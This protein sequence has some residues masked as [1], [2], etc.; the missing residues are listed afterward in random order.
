MP[1]PPTAASASDGHDGE[2][3]TQQ[4]D[5]ALGGTQELGQASHG[6]GGANGGGGGDPHG[7]PA[8]VAAPWAYT[9]SIPGHE[10]HV[11]CLA[12]HPTHDELAASGGKDSAVLLWDVGGTAKAL[13]SL[14]PHDPLDITFGRAASE[15]CLFVAADAKTYA[16]GQQGNGQLSMWDLEAGK[17]VYALPQPRGHVSCLHCAHHGQTFLVGAA[18]GTVRLMSSLDGNE[19][20][21]FK[22]GMSDVNLVSLLRRDICASVG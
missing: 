9:G 1:A 8:Q 15:G 21:T 12:T 14:R 22:T 20:F 5:T 17:C 11:I 18:D 13:R 6:G 3:S 2:S 16:N 10:D 19:V 4:Q 7:D